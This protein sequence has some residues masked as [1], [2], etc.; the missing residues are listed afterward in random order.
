VPTD[1]PLTDASQLNP[2]DR[3]RL[4]ARPEINGV[5]TAVLTHGPE[6]QY[7]VFHDNEIHTYYASQIEPLPD[8]S[9]TVIDAHDF[10]AGITA[11]QLLHP[12]MRFL[13]SLNAGRIDFEA[14][15]Y[16]PVLKLIQSDRPRLLIA[17]DVGVGKTIEACLILKELQAR[18]EVRS[19]LV[20]CPKPLVSEQKWEDEL[21]R[22]DEDFAPLDGALMRYCLEEY[23]KEGVWPS[24]YR[25]AIVPFSILDE[26][27]LLGTKG[28]SASPG[29]GTLSPP[30][31]F[32]LLIVDEAHH[33]RNRKTWRYQNLEYLVG[34]S[35]AVV[36][37]SAT[38]IQ[39]SDDDLFTLLNLL[40]P[41]LIRGGRI[42]SRCS[43]P[44][45]T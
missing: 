22:F 9:S 12:S 6:I 26:R 8:S 27:L 21:R 7:L 14:Y 33:A 23:Q 32:D 36:F 15:Q 31:K 42:S 17:D 29:L 38:P 45:R 30:L 40:R 25:R 11:A 19:V 24:R 37:L 39:T 43:S 3:A 34:A 2:G 13:Y 28:R 1:F 44:T 16:R 4:V 41:D 35:E 5:I 18:Q 10:H 20:V